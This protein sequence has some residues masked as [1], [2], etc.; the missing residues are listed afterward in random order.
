MICRV[1]S[2]SSAQRGVIIAARPSTDVLRRGT[3]VQRSRE[4]S[5][6]SFRR[7][8]AHSAA[9]DGRSPGD[10]RADDSCRD[11]IEPAAGSRGGNEHCMKA[12]GVGPARRRSSVVVFPV[13]DPRPRDH[14]QLWRG[15][16][17]GP[18]RPRPWHRRADARRPRGVVAW[19][20]WTRATRDERG[21]CAKNSPQDLSQ[22][23]CLSLPKPQVL[24]QEIKQNASAAS[25]SHSLSAAAHA[26]PQ[27]RCPVVGV[28]AR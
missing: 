10:Q 20:Q 18:L 3:C 16:T 5:L 9:A 6:A 22:T 14:V 13:N 4:S 23:A 12:M 1:F 7:M 2:R 17:G 19:Q 15:S 27:A 25:Y 24:L 11:T 21:R 26:M 28:M 8:R